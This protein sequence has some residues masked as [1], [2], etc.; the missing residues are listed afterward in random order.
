MCVCVCRCAR[1]KRQFVRHFTGVIIFF[2]SLSFLFETLT[3][4]LE[5][6]LYRFGNLFTSGLKNGCDNG[7][8]GSK[9]RENAEIKEVKQEK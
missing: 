1:I 2:L 9:K 6:K 3:Q 4:K 5:T 7:C 8:L